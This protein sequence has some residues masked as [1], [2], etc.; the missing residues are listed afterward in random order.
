MKRLLGN[1]IFD[2]SFTNILVLF[3]Q[4]S[5]FLLLNSGKIIGLGST[6]WF[7]GPQD[8]VLSRY[9]ND[10]LGIEDQH[11]EKLSVFPNPSNGTFKIQ[12][13]YLAAETPYLITDVLGKII[14]KDVYPL[15]CNGIESSV[16]IDHPEDFIFAEYLLKLKSNNNEK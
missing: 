4:H 2:A 8:F 13:D 1:G 14:T 3:A 5:S 7:D 11:L 6:F 10:P 15:V 16:D 9:N 12:H